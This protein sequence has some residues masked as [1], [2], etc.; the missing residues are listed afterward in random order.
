MK[1]VAIALLLVAILI[2]GSWYCIRKYQNRIL[3]RDRESFEAG[4]EVGRKQMPQVWIR[5]DE[6]RP[7]TEEEYRAFVES[8]SSKKDGGE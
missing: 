6:F 1:N 8:L 3:A 7:L 4:I 2:G 5:D